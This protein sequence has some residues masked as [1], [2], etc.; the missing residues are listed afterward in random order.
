MH[1]VHVDVVEGEGHGDRHEDG[2]DAPGHHVP[3]GLLRDELPDDDGWEGRGGHLKLAS[4][5]SARGLE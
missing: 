1:S 5:V 3:L 4:W 2:G